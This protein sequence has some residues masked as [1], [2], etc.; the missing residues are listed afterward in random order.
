M[1]TKLFKLIGIA[2]VASVLVGGCSG[3]N[4]QASPE[5][6]QSQLA[7]PSAKASEL[8]C[9]SD[10]NASTIDFLNF[11]DIMYEL[12]S[13]STNA[14]GIQVEALTGDP[15]GEVGRSA[16]N[17]CHEDV[18]SN[19]D[20]AVLKKGTKIYEMKGYMP[21]FR[22]IADGR[23][24][25]VREN[26]NASRIEEVLDI[27]G[28]VKKVVEEDRSSGEEIREL[29]ADNAEAFV[30]GVLNL[31][32]VDPKQLNTDTSA[33]DRLFRIQLT[34]GTSVRFAYYPA[35]SMLSFGATATYEI[36]TFL[37]SNP[38]FLE[39]IANQ[40]S[41]ESPDGHFLIETYGE[42][43]GVTAAGLY[44]VEGIRLIDKASSNPLWS[45]PGYYVQ[46]F[47][48][49][50]DSRYVSVY[51]EARIW[52]GTVVVDTKDGSEIVLP[53]A[54]EVSKQWKDK[55][56]LSDNRPDPYFKVADWVDNSRV[57]VTFTWVGQN[58][59]EYSGNYVYDLAKRR[60]LDLN[61]HESSGGSSPPMETL[62]SALPDR[63]IYLY[64]QEDGVALHVGERIYNYD[65]IYTTPRQ[66]MPM[67]D[68]RDYDKDGK[69]ELVVK[70]NIGSG[71]GV[72]VDELHMVE[73]NDRPVKDVVFREDD[74][75][76]QLERAGIGFRTFEE[77]GE[78]F[79]EVKVG[80]ATDKVSLK[81][82]Q[83]DGNKFVQDRV[84]FGSIAHF[85]SDDGQ[86]Q[87]SFGFGV[88]LEGFPAPVYIGN[89]HADIAYE[90][91]K[92]TMSKYRFDEQE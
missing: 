63:D 74:Y 8:T 10:M 27:A 53:G 29:S 36:G 15:V 55:A 78:L 90:A 57:N 61:V 32:Y 5:T 37:T 28:K 51:H 38:G 49:S 21:Q 41:S 20:A 4:Q 52:G 43:K 14:D 11:N 91:G 18:P 40:T 79:G 46:E 22:L 33:G 76:K 3:K 73:I 35:N 83:A 47:K 70:L 69:D 19:G 44:P 23:I 9:T 58:Y 42:N 13:E 68:V 45:M 92:F 31:E 66:I 80:K 71:T 34:D 12:D 89:L 81:E 87:A 65:W 30:R 82:Y 56:T 67:M 84:W 86:L 6:T 25:Q 72:A 75:L 48:W 64:G 24:Y 85:N 77:K 59:E 26:P 62:V 7:S 17:A 88:F 16:A 2:S 60:I 54:D 50:P 1:S 39:P